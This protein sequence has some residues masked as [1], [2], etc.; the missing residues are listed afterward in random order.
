MLAAE[1]AGLS[2]TTIDALLEAV[3]QGRVDCFD[4]LVARVHGELRVMARAVMRTQKP[5]TLQ[6]TALVN[7][8][9]IRLVQGSPDF[10][11][12]AHFFGAA[13][14][15]MRQVLVEY[16]RRR[17]TRKRAG[18]ARRVTFSEIDVQVGEIDA[19]VL[20]LNEALVELARAEP[21]LCTLIELRYFA[22]YGLEE[23][24]RIQD[25]S[26]AAV[27]RDWT[28]ARAWLFRQLSGGSAA[29]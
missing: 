19:D 3:S 7:E 22:G 11:S 13:A 4:D 12:R 26:L 24:A 20:A 21:Q 17:G 18:E 1:E 10:E 6:P 5:G 23:I 27:K 8:A 28:L 9:Y 15:A 16:A 2:A 14:R 25:R 29:S